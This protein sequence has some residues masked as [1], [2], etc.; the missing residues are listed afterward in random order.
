M[1]DFIYSA[2]IDRYILVEFE[3]HMVKG[4]DFCKEKPYH[5]KKGSDIAHRLERYFETGI[6]DFSGYE[7][8]L[9]GLTVFEKEVLRVTS[10][11]PAGKTLRYSQVASLAGRPGAA[12]A[13]GNALSKNP[14]P[15]IIPCHR[16]V[17]SNGPG[18]FTG[19]LDIKLRLLQLE[20]VL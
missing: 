2:K 8:D 5:E 19:G 17:A 1:K 6:D 12:R 13:V 3:G 15:I 14:V 10:G 11:I 18:G 20:G 7:A 4:L 16:V 9:S